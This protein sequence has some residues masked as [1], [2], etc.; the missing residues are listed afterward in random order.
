M[1][2]IPEILR[3]FGFLLIWYG[4]QILGVIGG[5]ILKNDQLDTLNNNFDK[6]ED[7]KKDTLLKIGDNLLNIQS[8]INKEKLS[9]T[10]SETKEKNRA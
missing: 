9:V 3:D 5:I 1:W 7:D 10:N 6:L 4:H 2:K 8:L